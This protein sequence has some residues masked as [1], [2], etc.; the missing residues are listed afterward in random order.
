MGLPGLK[1]CTHSCI[2]RG[3]RKERAHRRNR[4]YEAC[5]WISRLHLCLFFSDEP[6]VY[7]FTVINL[8]CEYNYM[9]NPASLSRNSA[10]I[11]VVLGSPETVMTY[12]FLMSCWIVFANT[13]PPQFNSHFPSFSFMHITLNILG[14][15]NFFSLWRYH[16]NAFYR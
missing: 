12:Y 1:H 16:D 7:P 4:A 9:P 2:L 3:Q 14:D 13:N 10:N 6:I 8:S 15:G 5:P 11:W